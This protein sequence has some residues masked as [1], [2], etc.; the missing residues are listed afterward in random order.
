MHDYAAPGRFFYKFCF[1]INIPII[2]IYRLQLV[3]TGRLSCRAKSGNYFPTL[4]L[5]ARIS[6]CKHAAVVTVQGCANPFPWSCSGT[7]CCSNYWSLSQS[8][9]QAPSRLC[10]VPAWSFWFLS[11]FPLNT[12]QRNKLFRL[13]YHFIM[14]ESTK[15]K[16]WLLIFF[17]SPWCRSLFYI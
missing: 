4:K 6:V 13:L 2:S 11:T 16:F 9:S 5:F 1:I 10:P 12:S 7:A 15:P 8:F 14:N 3:Q 17:K